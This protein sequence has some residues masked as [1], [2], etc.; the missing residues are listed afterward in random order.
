MIENTDSIRVTIELVHPRATVEMLGYLPFFL[1]PADPRPAREQ[2]D[3][4]YGRYG[5][6]S[7][8][9]GWVLRDI[10]II[11]PGD[12][13][14]PILAKCKLRDETILFCG[15]AWTVIV[16]PDGQYEVARMD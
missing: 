6:W 4:H 7:P 5:G 2:F 9:N 15:G 1:D 8:M 12:P 10:D 11:Y 16:Q 13:P 3:D 14:R